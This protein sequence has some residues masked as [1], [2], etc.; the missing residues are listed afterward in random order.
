MN[1][2]HNLSIIKRYFIDERPDDW[3]YKGI[4][5]DERESYRWLALIDP[6]EVRYECSPTREEYWPISNGT[7]CIN[8]NWCGLNYR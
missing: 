1:N 3:W 8:Y 5:S 6:V 2:Y 7:K 4:R